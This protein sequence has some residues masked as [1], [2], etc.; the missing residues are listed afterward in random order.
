MG[1]MCP[2]RPVFKAARLA[3][4]PVPPDVLGMPDRPRRADP[5][6][7]DMTVDG[8][9]LPTRR[10][11]GF[12]IGGV[13]LRGALPALILLAVASAIALVVLFGLALLVVPALA[14]LGSLTLLS[15]LLGSR[16]R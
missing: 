1:E 14:V 10:R 13:R 12:R 7:L 8:V 2:G 15:R 16:R 9:L 3:K 4:R 5:P 6:T 11:T